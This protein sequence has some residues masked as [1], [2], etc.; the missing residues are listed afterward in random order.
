MRAEERIFSAEG[1]DLGFCCSINFIM[2]DSYFE[3]FGLIGG[4][5]P[6]VTALKS[7]SMSS[8][9]KGGSKV[10]ISYITHPNDQISDLLSYGSSFH[11]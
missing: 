2:W 9:L 3:Y 11:T 8:A 7:P 4:Y 6:S 5:T 1:R 10:V